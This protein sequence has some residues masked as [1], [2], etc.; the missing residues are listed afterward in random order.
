M[1][2]VHLRL[3]TQ[4]D[5]PYLTQIEAE[6]EKL[7]PPEVLPPHLAS[8]TSPEM[9]AGFL[10]AV[11]LWVAEDE[12]SGVVGFAAAEQIGDSLHI[13]EMDVLP[14]H[15]KQGVGAQLLQ[16]VCSAA[17]E[18]G[19]HHVTLTTFAHIPW[20]APFYAKHE[21]KEVLLFSG[22]EHLL[23]RLQLERESGLAHRVAMAKSV[24]KNG[25]PVC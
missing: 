24:S 12:T 22:V 21:F 14:S 11:L 4:S 10:A 20:N 15:G 8:S 7:F 17:R 16:L 13:V 9:L 18:R 23:R 6:A 1:N 5:L 3:A 2:T 19:C 25:R